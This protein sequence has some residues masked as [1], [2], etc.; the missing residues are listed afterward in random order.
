MRM[1]KILAVAVGISS[2][3]FGGCSTNQKDVPF[4]LH[5]HTFDYG[6]SIDSIT[7][8]IEEVDPFSITPSTF[9]VTASSSIP[10]GV[11]ADENNYGVYTD[12]ERVV[13]GVNVNGNTVELFLHCENGQSGEGTLS[14][15]SPNINKN[16]DVELSYTISQEK[17]ITV[18]DQ[19]ISA[20]TITFKQEGTYD[21]PEIDAF[22]SAKQNDM[23]YYY[24]VPDNADDGQLHPLVLWLHGY[25]EGGYSGVDATNSTLRANRAA[26]CFT[27]QEAQEIF[28]GAFVV[29]PQAPTSWIEDLFN[30]NYDQTILEIIDKMAG[31]YAIDVSRIYI[32]GASSGGYG[33]TW[34]ASRYPE[35]WAA[36][37]PICPGIASENIESR[38]GEA[39]SDEDILNLSQV[40]VW[41]IQ[42]ANDESVP[43]DQGS[44]RLYNLLSDSAIYTEY[45]TVN[46]DGVEYNGHWSWIYFAHNMPNNGETD[47]WTWMAAQSKE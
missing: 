17:D 38:G 30:R 45:E 29:A 9:K 22:Q 21:N 3:M 27:E 33:V 44:R 18:A 40:P 42:A 23:T 6:E 15:G 24:Y 28:S 19:T 5:A 16:I 10:D 35:R 34:M 46:V 4:H 47:I 32:A 11:E 2:L 43:I 36:A 41:T 37:V 8:E 25:G 7:F 39:L 31:E 14:Y 13:D 12:V 20:G 26:V 1:K